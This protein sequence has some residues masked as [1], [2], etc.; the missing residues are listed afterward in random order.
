MNHKA[1]L[2]SYLI[3]DSWVIPL[4]LW[5]AVCY[6]LWSG[7]EETTVLI[8]DWCL[9]YWMAS[10]EL[11]NSI[12]SRERAGIFFPID[13]SDYHFLSL[14][15]VFWVKHYHTEWVNNIKSHTQQWVV[16]NPKDSNLAFRG[17]LQGT[18]SRMQVPDAGSASSTMTNGLSSS[19]TTRRCWASSGGLRNGP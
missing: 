8:G 1:P 18:E 5:R 11:R 9:L 12:H 2:W 14:P 4:I 3:P 17:R 10:W 16:L 19:V 15:L 6:W 13:F 7:S